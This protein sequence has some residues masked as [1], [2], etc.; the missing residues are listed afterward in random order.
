MTRKS[1]EGQSKRGRPKKDY[2]H[3]LRLDV[4]IGQKEKEMLEHLEIESDKNKSEII[5][6]AIQMYYNFESKRW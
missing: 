2:S 3:G 6:K 4:R 5:R 1:E